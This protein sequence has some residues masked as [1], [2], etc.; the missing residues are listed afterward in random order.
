MLALLVHPS[1][2]HN[3]ANRFSWA[4]CVYLEAVSVLPQLR[5]MQNTK[6]NNRMQFLTLCEVCW[7][8]ILCRLWNRSQLTMCLR[9][10]LRGFLA[11]PTGFSRFV[12]WKKVPEPILYIRVMFIAYLVSVIWVAAFCVH[13][14]CCQLCLYTVVYDEWW[15][16]SFLDMCVHHYSVGLFRHSCLP[17]KKCNLYG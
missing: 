10:G 6:V 2:S 13:F 5:L 12:F 8:T 11:A 15:C 16:V 14:C 1:T 3:I 7:Q 17:C 4:F 9:W